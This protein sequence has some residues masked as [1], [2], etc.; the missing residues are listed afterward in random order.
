MPIKKS[1]QINLIPQ[2]DFEVSTIGR[3]L[4]WALSTFRVMVIVTELIV[5]S[6]FLSR[7]WLDTRNSDLNEEIKVNKT[8]ILAYRDVERQFRSMK[9]RLSIAK[10]MYSNPMVNDL[11]SEVTQIVPEDIMLSSISVAEK[12]VTIKSFSFSEKSIAQF[13]ANIDKLKSVEKANIAQISSSIGDNIATSFVIKA[14]IK[15]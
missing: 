6:A 7:F 13:L 4:K 8:Q 11:L 14:A 5:M 3:I 1:K 12:Q 15:D 9:S 2:N 10:K